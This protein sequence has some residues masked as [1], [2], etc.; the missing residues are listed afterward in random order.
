[1]KTSI[2]PNPSLTIYQFNQALVHYNLS[3]FNVKFNLEEYFDICFPNLGFVTLNF[4]SGEN[5][6]QSFPEND[7]QDSINSHIYTSGLLSTKPFISRQI[8]NG[9]L[10][11]LKMHPVVAYHLLREPMVNITDKRIALCDIF[12]RSWRVLNV[13]ENEQNI[14]S[15]QDKPLSKFIINHLPCWI[16]L[17]QDPI[18]HAVNIIIKNKGLIKVRELAR[19]VC[20]T[21]RSLNR[22]FTTEVGLSPKAYAKIWQWQ[23]VAELLYIEPSISLQDLAFKT[24]YYDIS[25]LIHDYKVRTGKTPNEFQ[26][27]IN[28]LIE[29]YIE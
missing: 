19:R 6:H 29:S 9:E 3:C 7:I 1:M 15:F 14:N 2:Q 16:K 26:K 11:G 20:L 23:Y 21:E 22:K 8:G 17:Q 10:N 12:G 25:H 24:G 18:Y 13:L 5:F 28:F 4:T 27:Q